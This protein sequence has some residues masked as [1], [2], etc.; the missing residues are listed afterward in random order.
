M[1]SLY[2]TKY[3]TTDKLWAD[4]YNIDDVVTSVENYLNV[5]DILLFPTI[6]LGAINKIPVN[7]FYPEEEVWFFSVHAEWLAKRKKFLSLALFDREE[8]VKLFPEDFC[9]K[10]SPD[11]LLYSRTNPITVKQQAQ[12]WLLDR[13]QTCNVQSV[14][15]LKLIFQEMQNSIS[16]RNA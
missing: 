5:K 9:G 6:A 8:N 3:M 4:Y 14:Y 16:W 12:S 13:G 2:P 11:I 1:L 7:G 10:F 15:H